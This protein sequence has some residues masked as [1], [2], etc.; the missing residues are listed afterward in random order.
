MTEYDEALKAAEYSEKLQYIYPDK[1][2]NNQSNNTL[3]SRNRFNPPCNECVSSNLAKNFLKL[4]DKHFS[5]TS[6]LKKYFNKNTMKVSYSCMPNMISIIASHNRKILNTQHSTQ[7]KGCNC[8]GGATTCPLD[9]KCLT[10]SLIYKAIFKAGDQK[11]EY[12]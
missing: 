8:R 7:I 12:I 2:N 3:R 10:E 9:C 4:I 5:K 11:A 1:L 6:P